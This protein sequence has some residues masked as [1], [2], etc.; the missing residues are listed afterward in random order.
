[1]SRGKN[2]LADNTPSISGGRVV[3]QVLPLS[4]ER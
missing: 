2:E 3:R 1:M 4:I